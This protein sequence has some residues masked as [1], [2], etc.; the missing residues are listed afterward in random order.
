MSHIELIMEV[1]CSLSKVPF[2]ISMECQSGFDNWANLF[3]DGSL[4]LGVMLVQISLING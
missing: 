2:Y 1:L 4:E 3:L